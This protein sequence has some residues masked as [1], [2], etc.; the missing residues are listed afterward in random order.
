[1]FQQ[2]KKTN[3]SFSSEIVSDCMENNDLHFLS[4]ITYICYRIQLFCSLLDGRIRNRFRSKQWKMGPYL[5]GNTFK[6]QNETLSH[7]PDLIH[8]KNFNNLIILEEII[9]TQPFI[10]ITY[11]FDKIINQESILA[12]GLSLLFC[13]PFWIFCFI[14]L[15]I[16]LFINIIVLNYSGGGEGQTMNGDILVL[17]NIN[18]FYW[19]SLYWR[20][21][22]TGHIGVLMDINILIV[23]VF[24]GDRSW[25]GML[26]VNG[27]KY[28]YI[29]SFY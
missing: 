8:L 10:V 2:T 16:F 15:L 22:M 27:Y 3:L 7:E 11:F 26:C 21:I 18:I 14:C 28:Y 20:Q 17:M 23:I 13:Y 12:F 25:L 1:M 4:M 19:Y 6:N 9:I 29:Y 5:S 24:T